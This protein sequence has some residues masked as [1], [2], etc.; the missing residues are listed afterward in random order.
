MALPPCSHRV[1][2]RFWQRWKAG[3]CP[4][5]EISS[6]TVQT[7]HAPIAERGCLLLADFVAKVFFG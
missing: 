3:Q 7:E 6:G 5:V 1:P 4:H 2:A